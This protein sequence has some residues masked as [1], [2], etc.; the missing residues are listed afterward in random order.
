MK[1]VALIGFMGAGKTDVGRCL[2]KR[3]NLPFVDLDAEIEIKA[4][5]RI[6]E[7]FATDGEPAFRKLETEALQSLKQPW[8]H[9]LAPGGGVVLKPENVN[10]LQENYLIV[11]LKAKK[12][13]LRKRLKKSYNRPLLAGNFSAQL[14]SLYNARQQLYQQVA[15]KQITTDNLSVAEVVNQIVKFVNSKAV[16]TVKVN[17][18]QDSYP[19]YIGEGLLENLAAY[20]ANQLFLNQAIAK[21]SKSLNGM[22]V[23]NSKEKALQA[24]GW[25]NRAVIITNPIVGRHWGEKVKE[26]L[27]KVF[28]HIDYKEIPAGER[29][30][31]WRTALKLYD[32]LLAVGAD[33]QTVLVALG[34]GV[35]GDL[36]GFVAATFM[37]GLPYLQIPTTLMAQVDSSIGGK[38]AVNHRL[39]KNIIGAFYQPKAVFIDPL[40]LKTLPKRE[41][42]NGL[43]EIIKYA[44]IAN[45]PAT[46][47]LAN[48]LG[49]PYLT[50]C[51]DWLIAQ[52]VAV[53]AKIV[54][55]DEKEQG[56]RA[57]LNYGHTI[58]HGLEAATSY[59]QLRHGEAVALGMLAAA[60]L[61]HQLGYISPELVELHYELIKKAD[62]PTN[63][64]ANVSEAEVL[65]RL[66]YD[67]KR[68]AN[69][70]RF[71]LLKDLGKPELLFVGSD[72]I[73]KAKLS[74]FSPP[75]QS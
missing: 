66:F 44:F 52:S 26:Q 34:G 24:D 6:F 33:R 74:S 4:G 7:I 42:K 58:G 22:S 21:K 9:I 18:N 45:K 57:V 5:K 37:R 10:W 72:D 15:H 56:L 51:L 62:L 54:S 19:I 17:L 3:L 36:V 73:A 69:K 68:L 32:Y 46:K 47:V 11:Y 31:S 48:T 64:P 35:I 65:K 43:S 16:T 25:K 59:Q 40:V 20:L 28:A 38:T 2:A 53:K 23:Q 60:N 70:P 71:V 8:P 1:A 67:K 39:A 49:T 50:N 63:W 12:E 41:F 13:T 55:G 14:D 61:A 27:L 29:F 30:K 75:R